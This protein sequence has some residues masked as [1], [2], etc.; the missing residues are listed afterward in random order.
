LFQL[1]FVDF[2]VF[3]VALEESALVL[4]GV[5]LPTLR[6]LL[7]L[8]QR[9]VDCTVAEAVELCVV[10][11]LVEKALDHLAAAFP[12][13][14]ANQHVHVVDAIEHRARRALGAQPVREQDRARCRLPT[15][16]QVSQQSV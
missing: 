14:K 6:R 2:G 11:E 12:Q 1:D 7:V 13:H 4:E 9:E 10:L 3:V 16:H 15:I 5:V 8:G